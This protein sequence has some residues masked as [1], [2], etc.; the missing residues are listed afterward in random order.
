MPTLDLRRLNALALDAFRELGNIGS[1]HASGA[2]AT[3]LGKKVNITVPKV[4]LLSL[5]DLAS[6]YPERS[7]IVA[8][9]LRLDGDLQGLVS[10]CA[11]VDTA[12]Q[13]IQMLT[14][15]SIPV[16]DPM[17]VSVINEIANIVGGSYLSAF[18]GLT[19]LNAF[20][21]PPQYHSGS[22]NTVFSSALKEAE[23]W[24]E[25]AFAVESDFVHDTDV[26]PLHLFFIPSPEG[27][28]EILARM[29]LQEIFV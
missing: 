26:L 11:P 1:G 21:T 2:L 5:G 13:F 23:A 29:G 7:T 14:G 28:V 9:H 10:L 24:G 18:Y 19:G 20:L 8:V 3:L 4:E 22:Y 16:D 15:M 25:Y 27:L 12:R 17:G 6:L